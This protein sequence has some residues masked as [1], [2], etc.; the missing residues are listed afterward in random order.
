[1]FRPNLLPYISYAYLDVEL[2][3]IGVY[4]CSIHM[5]EKRN[6]LHVGPK[7]N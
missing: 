5:K 6:V 4:G 7:S 1:M 3:V 2:A